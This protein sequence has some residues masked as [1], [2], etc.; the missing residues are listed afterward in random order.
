MGGEKGLLLGIELPDGK[1][2]LEVLGEVVWYDLAAQ[3]SD[4]RFRAGVLFSQMGEE[5]SRRWHD[6]ISTLRKKRIP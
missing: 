3:D 4:Y 5:A 6:Y 2:P 1:D